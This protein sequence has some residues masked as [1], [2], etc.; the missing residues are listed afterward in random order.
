MSLD[1]VIGGIQPKLAG[2]QDAIVIPFNPP[3]IP[4][5]GRR[6]ASSSGCRT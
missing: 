3:P 6:V 5:L 2:I 4:G 1:A